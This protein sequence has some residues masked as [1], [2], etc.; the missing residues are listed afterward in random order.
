MG[1]PGWPDLAFS[2]ESTHSSLIVI[3]RSISKFCSVI[4]YPLPLVLSLLE[5]PAN[6]QRISFSKQ[7]CSSMII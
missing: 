5:H 4:I 6:Y 2:T 1:A 7:V 3:M